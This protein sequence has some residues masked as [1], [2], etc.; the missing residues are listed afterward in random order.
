MLSVCVQGTTRRRKY[1][2][3]EEE[4]REAFFH[5]LLAGTQLEEDRA[6]TISE[7]RMSCVLQVMKYVPIIPGTAT[8]RPPQ[9]GRRDTTLHP[10]TLPP[11]PLTVQ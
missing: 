8:A 3:G 9:R 1:S 6:T 7:L 11:P 10:P 4:R 5:F 2:R